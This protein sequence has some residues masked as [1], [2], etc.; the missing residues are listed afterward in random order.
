MIVT[1][2]NHDVPCLWFLFSAVSF[3]L[4]DYDNASVNK[5]QHIIYT[6]IAYL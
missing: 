3:F 2:Y 1:S 4:Y 6:F 5:L